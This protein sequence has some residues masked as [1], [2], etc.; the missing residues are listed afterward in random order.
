M[1]TTMLSLSDCRKDNLLL[2]LDFYS[3][4]AFNAYI[5]IKHGKCYERSACRMVFIF[6]KCQF[7][8]FNQIHDGTRSDPAMKQ[9]LLHLDEKLA[10]GRK[11]IIQDLDENHLFISTD[12]VEV[13]QARVDEL[14]DRISF[15]LHEKDA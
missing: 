7:I 2:A 14:M 11:F 6:Y 4:I 13:L 12:I 8:F 1:A 9:F 5:A 15:P 10:L 3:C